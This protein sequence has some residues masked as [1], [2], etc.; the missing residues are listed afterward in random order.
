M[1]TTSRRPRALATTVSRWL[2]VGAI[3]LFTSLV[4]AQSAGAQATPEGTVITNTASASWTDANNNTYTAVTANVSVTVGFTAG[5]TT[6][7]PAIVTPTS[8]ST[9]NTLN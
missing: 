9:G 3:M 2:T 6:T 1:R 4:T 7:S 8:P 5:V